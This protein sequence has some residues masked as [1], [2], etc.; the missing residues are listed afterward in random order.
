VRS[1]QHLSHYLTLDILSGVS[2]ALGVFRGSRLL[3]QNPGVSTGIAM[4]ILTL[5]RDVHWEA[6]VHKKNKLPIQRTYNNKK[7]LVI[8]IAK[9]WHKSCIF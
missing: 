3:P 9:V 6:D 4:D 7:Q 8:S 1:S 2:R 5:F